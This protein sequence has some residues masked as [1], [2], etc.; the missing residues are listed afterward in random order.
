M[1]AEKEW[2]GEAEGVSYTYEGYEIKA[3]DKVSL[4]LGWGRE[5]AFMGENG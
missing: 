2:M 1:R 5:I 3:L 4:Q